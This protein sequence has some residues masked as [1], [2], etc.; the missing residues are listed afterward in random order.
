MFPKM[1]LVL[2]LV[3]FFSTSFAREKAEIFVSAA[4]SLKDVFTKLGSDFENRHKVKVLFNFAG[5]G[6]LKTQIE[7]GAPVDVFA[8]ASSVDMDYLEKKDLLLPGTRNDFARN[9]IVLAQNINS[10]FKIDKI[11]DLEK[12]EIKRIALGNPQT[13]PAGRY[14]KEVLVN[15]KSF[16]ILKPKMI[17]GETVRQVLDYIVL[18]EVDAGFVFASDVFNNKKVNVVLRIPHDQHSP[19]IYPIAVIKSS[20]NQTHANAF[21]SFIHS[22]E[23]QGIFEK[24]GFKK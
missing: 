12:T 1:I 7:N 23:N 10:K 5:S 2:L 15:A 9:E 11:A 21:I 4:S 16:E 17:Y 13:V 20:K 24:Y 18:G 22:K 19:I 14:A 3:L 8:S 6:Q